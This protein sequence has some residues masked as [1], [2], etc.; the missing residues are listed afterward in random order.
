MVSKYGVPPA[1]TRSLQLEIVQGTML[2]GAELTWNGKNRVEKEYQDAINCM[3]RATLG[4]LRSTPLGIL[5][6]E[7]GLI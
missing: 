2:Y 3:G 1:S 7:S 4:T 5:V 6:A